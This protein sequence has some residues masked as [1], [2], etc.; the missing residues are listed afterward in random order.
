MGQIICPP[1]HRSTAQLSL[2]TCTF[3]PFEEGS[4]VDQAGL[5]CLRSQDDFA[6]L[7]LPPAPSL[8]GLQERTTMLLYEVLSPK[9]TSQP[10]SQLSH[11]PRPPPARPLAGLATWASGQVC[12]L[13]SIVNLT[14]KLESPGKTDPQLKKCLHHLAFRHVCREFS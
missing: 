1:S 12:W 3:S 6:L 7:C 11:T 4:N 8:Q 2:Q 10:L 13:I 5:K 14:Q 9:P